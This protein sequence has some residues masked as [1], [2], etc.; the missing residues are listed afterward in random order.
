MQVIFETKRLRVR[1][2]MM[3]DFEPFHE[4]HSNINVMQF[5]RGK[6]MT[7]EENEKELPMLIDKY[8]DPKNDFWIYA[9]ERKEDLNFVGT[10]AL[11]KDDHN[12]DEIGYRFLEKYWKNG[13]GFEIA[14]GLV[15]HCRKVGVPKIIAKVVNK[16]EASTKIIKKLGF[17]FVE[18][19]V[20]DDLK[21][22][23]RKF[24]LQ[25]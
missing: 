15:G 6:A 22:P 14:E 13:Y 23:E 8:D 11:V 4:M 9:V 10:V 21:V 2:L 18:D 1:K 19:F 12:D 7:Y 5:V 20:S 25:L 16:N 17:D 3:N 24:I